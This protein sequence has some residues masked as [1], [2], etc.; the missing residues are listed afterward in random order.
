MFSKYAILPQLNP[1]KALQRLQR[2]AL[3]AVALLGSSSAVQALTSSQ[4]G[5][6]ADAATWGGTA[7][8]FL[9]SAGAGDNLE[10]NHAITVG[11]TN[12]SVSK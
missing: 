6:W 4:A 12:V 2:A 8:A 7:P 5:A 3:L 1:M 9:T 11:N 10:I